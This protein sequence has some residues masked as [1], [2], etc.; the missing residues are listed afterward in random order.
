MFI[1]Y[2]KP[3]SH[4]IQVYI[5]CP[6]IMLLYATSD[7]PNRKDRRHTFRLTFRKCELF[8]PI[9][10]KKRDK[11]F[12]PTAIFGLFR[13]NNKRSIGHWMVHIRN[14]IDL[15][16]STQR[17][18]RHQSRT[19]IPKP[20]QCLFTGWQQITISFWWQWNVWFPVQDRK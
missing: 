15:H 11:F 4:E 1:N 9:K 16:R 8:H 2:Q 3:K 10:L 7:N 12:Y 13:T 18:F 20:R 14:I 6:I 17:P 5:I 19:I